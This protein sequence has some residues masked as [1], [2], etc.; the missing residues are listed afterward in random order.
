VTITCQIK[1]TYF[2]N[3]HL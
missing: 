2:L 1:A 3:Y